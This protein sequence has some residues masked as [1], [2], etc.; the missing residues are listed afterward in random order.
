MT[1][2]SQLLAYAVIA[3][4]LACIY[5]FPPIRSR[6]QAARLVVGMF[7]VLLVVVPNTQP[8]S[9]QTALEVIA[10]AEK[11]VTATTAEP[12]LVV[13]VQLA[14]PSG[15]GPNREVLIPRSMSGDRGRYF[16]ISAVESSGVFN[17]LH[18]RVSVD[19]VGWTRTEIDCR[20]V[21]IRETSDTA[22]KAPTRSGIIQRGG[23]NWPPAPARAI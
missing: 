21:L 22:R 9:A 1:A 6:M 7:A 15:I 12:P 17:T 3:S 20:K 18:M 8:R 16:L 5:P 19:S 11:W 13:P 14:G 10:P 4:V 2:L 23:T